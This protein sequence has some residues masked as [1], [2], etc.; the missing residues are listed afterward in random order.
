MEA[1]GGPRAGAARGRGS[2][3]L[4]TP[5]PDG[6]RRDVRGPGPPRGRDGGEVRPGRAAAARRLE[7]RPL[8][9]DAALRALT[10]LPA[11]LA[12]A[13]GGGGRARTADRRVAGQGA[14]APRRD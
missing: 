3:L 2:D 5:L 11:R 7:P 10:R 4:G 14:E 13:R 9:A 12:R 1:G 8:P 6:A